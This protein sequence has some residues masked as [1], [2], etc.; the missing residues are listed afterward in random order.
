MPFYYYNYINNFNIDEWV[1][2]DN[3]DGADDEKDI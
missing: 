1:N 2:D 3:N